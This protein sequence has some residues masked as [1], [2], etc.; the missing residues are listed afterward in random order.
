VSAQ[1]SLAALAVV[2]LLV[3]AAPWASRAADEAAVLR[4]HAEQLAAEDRCEEALVRARRA[5]ELDPGDA[6]AALVEGRCLLREG[7]YR[8]AI[9]SLTAAREA[10]PALPGVS[11]DLAQCHYHLDELEAASAELDR[12][13][14]R[15]PDDARMHLYR[16]LVLARDSRAA[17]A[18]TSIDRAASHDPALA[19]VAGLYAGRSW[20]AVRD[21]DK[22]AAA[23]ERA[24]DAEPDSEWARA[25]ERELDTLEAPYH[26]NRWLRLRGGVEYDDNVALRISGSSTNPLNDIFDPGD[27]FF[28]FGE[29]DDWRGTWEGEVGAELL[30]DPDQSLGGMVGYQGNAHFE[31]FHVL[32]LQYPW[33][34]FWYDKRLDEDTWVRLQPFAGYAWLETDPYFAHGGGVVSLSHALSDTL[35]AQL[36]TRVNAN[37]F[38]YRITPDPILSSAVVNGFAPGIGDDA[39]RRRNRD[40]VSVE[41]GTEWTW[42]L[43]GLETVLRVGGSYVRYE[44][45]G[46]DWDMHAGRGWVEIQ[47]PLPFH[48]LLVLDGRFTYED[49][50][51]RSSYLAPNVYLFGG[52]KRRDRIYEAEAEL[53]YPL[54]EWLTVSARYRYADNVSNTAVFD[55][56][57]H[58][59][60]GYLTVHWID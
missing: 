44:S 59:V 5:R 29:R 14:A 53:F 25:A 19:E 9:A 48:F 39:R 10:D 36:F 24:R 37:D 18:A 11:T 16:G 8:E 52:P 45:E 51:H 1:R 12:A 38:H 58:I 56:D 32:D 60:G 55:Y 34:S 20:A 33:V 3:F 35:G 50:D 43:T 6:R 46:R 2:G 42:L 47:Q 31:E 27:D 26:R 13:E 21:R 41:P 30:R 23:F 17:E 15:D 22:A 57:R 28:D 49:Y 40:G 4:Q 54:T 7:F